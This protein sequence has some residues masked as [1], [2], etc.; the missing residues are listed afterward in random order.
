MIKKIVFLVE[1]V[2]TIRDYQRFGIE[3]L[4]KKMSMIKIINRALTVLE[5]I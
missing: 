4:Q 2:F 1:T 5:I 3:L